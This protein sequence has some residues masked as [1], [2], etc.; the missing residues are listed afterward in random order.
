MHMFT[1][2]WRC[3]YVDP[4]MNWANNFECPRWHLC[5]CRME[6]S[7]LCYFYTFP[8]QIGELSGCN[9]V[10]W[11]CMLSYGTVCCPM[12]VYVPVGPC[13]GGYWHRGFSYGRLCLGGFCLGIICWEFCI[14]RLLPIIKCKGGG[15]RLKVIL[16][17]IYHVKMWLL[18]LCML[19][20]QAINN[21][22]KITCCIYNV[23]L[24]VKRF[25]IWFGKDRP[26]QGASWHAMRSF[27]EK[28]YGC[29]HNIYATNEMENCLTV[30]LA[31]AFYSCSPIPTKLGSYNMHT[32]K[33]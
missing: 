29:Q 17:A 11:E 32:L 20:F 28:Q 33:I 5:L 2:R 14:G 7:Y 15:F 26:I 31:E 27:P 18:L 16:L 8:C 10:L 25:G 30:D 23:I 4:M 19:D 6:A 21:I 12:G 13:P 22:T 3:C 24:R 1:A 9:V